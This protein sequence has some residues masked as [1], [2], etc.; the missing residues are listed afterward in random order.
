MNA[1]NDPTPGA[2]LADPERAFAEAASAGEPLPEDVARAPAPV[3]PRELDVEPDVEPEAERE[4][5]PEPIDD[6]PAPDAAP[7]RLG[8]YL[9]GK[10]IGTGGS[11][12]VHSAV[13]ETLRRPTAIKV[14]APR[15]SQDPDY[16]KRFDREA[17]VAAKLTHANIVSIY[18]YGEDGGLLYLAME[19]IE[20]RN[21]T[22]LLADEGRL[23]TVQAIKIA[24]DVALALDYAARHGIIHRDIKPQNILITDDG[25]T[26]L[27]D[28]GLAK[29]RQAANSLTATGTVLGTPRYMSPETV[30]GRREID[31]RSDIYSLGVILYAMITGKVP[32]EGGTIVETFLRHTQEDVP[33]PSG[34]APTVSEEVDAVVAHMTARKRTRRYPDARALVEDL[35]ALLRDQEPRHALAAAARPPSGETPSASLADEPKATTRAKSG[36]QGGRPGSDRRRRSGPRATGRGSSGDVTPSRGVRAV[37]PRGRRAAAASAAGAGHGA[38]S[39]RHAGAILAAV[40]IVTALALGVGIGAL[41]MGSEGRDAS[42]PETARHETSP[43]GTTDAAAGRTDAPAAAAPELVRDLALAVRDLTSDGEHLR[44][45]RLAAEE[46]PRIPRGTPE[47]GALEL[48]ERDALDAFAASARDVGARDGAS[49]AFVVLDEAIDVV[50]EEH[51]ATLSGVA[52]AVAAGVIGD[53]APARLGEVIPPMLRKGELGLVTEL[54]DRRGAALEEVLGHA[55]ASTVAADLVR[56]A[57]VAAGREAIAFWRRVDEAA[58]QAKAA[59]ALAGDD[60][61]VEAAWGFVTLRTAQGAARVPFA[62][63][64]DDVLGRVLGL[65]LAASSDRVDLALILAFFGGEER[66]RPVLE[67]DAGDFAWA[68]SFAAIAATVVPRVEVVAATDGAAEAPGTPP[69]PGGAEPNEGDPE[70][71]AVAPPGDA[72]PESGREPKRA[73]GEQVASVLAESA[74]VIQKLREVGQL[75]SVAKLYLR[76]KKTLALGDLLAG[77]PASV[78]RELA[79][80]SFLERAVVGD[81]A[82]VAEA[83]AAVRAAEKEMRA[84]NRKGDA[85]R[86]DLVEDVEALA[87]LTAS[88]FEGDPR[89]AV[90]VL[91]RER[92]AGSETATELLGSRGLAIVRR[93]AEARAWLGQWL[94]A[95][96]DRDARGDLV[97]EQEERL[98]T[99]YRLSERSE[100]DRLEASVALAALRAV[101]PVRDIMREADDRG[102]ITIP[103]DDGLGLAALGGAHEGTWRWDADGLRLEPDDARKVGKRFARQQVW[104]EV[105]RALVYERI[106]IVLAEAL[107]PR[108]GLAV[109]YGKGL[110][111]AASEPITGHVSE[112]GLFLG[113]GTDPL[114]AFLG[115]A[116]RLFGKQT[117]TD[118]TTVSGR[119]NDL[120]VQ[121]SMRAD[122]DDRM[123]FRLE[124]ER[125]ETPKVVRPGYSSSVDLRLFPAPGTVIRS[126]RLRFDD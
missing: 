125:G 85:L 115:A 6:S 51:Y 111:S 124:T 59:V 62:R 89:I 20:G 48:A 80:A 118:R 12:T 103:L 17:R 61:I 92:G 79:F 47:R 38:P 24:R 58:R 32:L 106:E 69:A 70:V 45:L 7:E 44:A 72:A 60:T 34:L 96:H 113:D 105:P 50:R 88:A 77:Q 18:D 64:G 40:G 121:L 28:M 109:T 41:L 83:I 3:A 1:Q 2:I 73:L 86:K 71:G 87:I 31:V 54:L 22:R 98:R 104:L 114:S 39:A 29:E 63:C 108:L 119:E 9:I 36:R 56:G 99:L 101:K 68:R 16:A 49:T 110:K 123:L 33:A 46:L 102:T 23:P 19:L 43:S 27:V 112:K 78:R 10:P 21:L 75:A 35:T 82:G 122:I 95:M 116:K 107:K 76:I 52:A 93:T 81:P 74:D 97:D 26:K 53:V 15:L 84:E 8:P 66:S 57:D 67:A 90:E 30:L 100:N 126:I 37:K 91:L 94:R 55:G 25:T 120:T 5:E 11:A 14:L 42:T 13:H 65:E 117:R 4:P